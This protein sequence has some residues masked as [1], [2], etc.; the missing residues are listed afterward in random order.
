MF[1]LATALTIGAARDQAAGFE[2]DQL[3]R[4]VSAEIAEPAH[5]LRIADCQLQ[6]TAHRTWK[7]TDREKG[8][9]G[10]EFNDVP[11]DD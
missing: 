1:T 10:S 4:A 11:I 6:K 3:S 5:G 8:R 9:S 7:Q 2:A